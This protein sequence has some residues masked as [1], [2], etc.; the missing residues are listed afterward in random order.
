MRLKKAFE[1]ADAVDVIHAGDTVAS[2]GYAGR[3][4]RTNSSSP[5]SSDS[6]SQE[7]HAISRSC[8]RRAKAP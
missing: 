1:P 4:T 8:F 6:S 3:G 7:V 5:L 2:A